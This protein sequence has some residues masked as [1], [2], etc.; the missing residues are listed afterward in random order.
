MGNLPQPFG[1]GRVSN[2]LPATLITTAITLWIAAITAL[3][4]WKLLTGSIDLRGLLQGDRAD[5]GVYFSP[6]RVQLLIFTLLA[7]VH[8]LSQVAT[9]PD[10]FPAI[11]H[12]LLLVL[13][14]SQLVYLGGKA[15]AML[16]F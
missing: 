3:M 11:P 9:H 8:L 16:R 12:E 5:G 4:A 13:G 7:A 15:R 10:R 1:G 14:G 6:G 2:Q